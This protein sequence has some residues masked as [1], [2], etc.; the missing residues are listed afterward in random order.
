VGPAV[1]GTNRVT[2]C[3]CISPSILNP[4]QLKWLISLNQ[5]YLRTLTFTHH[6]PQHG[7]FFQDQGTDAGIVRNLAVLQTSEARLL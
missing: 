6:A 5:T 7:S 3:V 1:D 4:I 2:K